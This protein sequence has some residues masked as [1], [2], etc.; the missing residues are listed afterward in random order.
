VSPTSRAGQEQVGEGD[1]RRSNINLV[2][3]VAFCE[4]IDAI[5]HLPTLALRVI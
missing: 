3:R 1:A 5:E 4:E 2:A